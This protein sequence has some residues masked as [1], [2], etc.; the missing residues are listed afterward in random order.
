MKSA[1]K[2]LFGVLAGACLAGSSSAALT[3]RSYIQ[4]GLAACYDGVDNAGAGVHDPNAT[5]WVD[6]TGHGNDGTVGSGITWAANGWV[7]TGGVDTPIV[8]GPGVA[9]VTGSET[10]T[11]EFTGTRATTGRGVLF[12][13]YAVNYGVNMEYTGDGS[14]TTSNALRLHFLH[15]LENNSTLNQYTTA[16]TVAFRNGDSA[17]LALTTAPTERGLWRNAVLGTFSDTTQSEMPIVN[18]TNTCNSCIDGDFRGGS[19]VTFIGTCNAFR[20]Y[21][22]VL[23]A[24]ELAINAAVD[25]VRFRGADPATF[26]LPAGWSFDAQT[27][28]VKAVAVSALGGTITPAGGVAVVSFATNVVQGAGTPTLTFTAVAD[29]GYEFMAWGGDTDAIVSA[30]GCEVT[31]RVDEPLSLYA[32]FRPDTPPTASTADYNYVTD[33]L[34]VWYDGADN[35]G[36]G[37]HDG[38]TSTWT[39]LSGNNRD[40]TLNAAL[41]WVANGWTNNS[42]CYPMALGSAANTA[43]ANALNSN[44]FTVEFMARPTRTTSRENYFGSYNT[45]GLSIEHNSSRNAIGQ[46]RLYYNGKPDYDADVTQVAGEAAVVALVSGPSSQKLYK[47]G[48]LMFTGTQT[49]AADKLLATATYYIGNDASRPNNAFRGTFHSFRVYNRLLTDE[50]VARNAAADRSRLLEGGATTWTNETG[51]AWLDVGSWDYGV[52]NVFTPAA[53]TQAGASKTVTVTEHVPA[54]TNVT[55]ANGPGTTQVRVVDGGRLSIENALVSVGKGGELKVEA[56]GRIDYSGSGASFAAGD[57][58]ISVADGGRLSIDGGTMELNDFKG[59]LIVSGSGTDTG[60]VS[61]AS[62]TLRFHVDSGLQGLQ[63]ITGGRLEMTGGLLEVA[64]TNAFADNFLRL[65]DGNGVVELSGDAQILYREVSAA[66]GNGTVHLRGH[67]SIRG[68]LTWDGVKNSTSAQARFRIAPTA[69]K[70]AVVTV[71][72]D[73][74][75]ALD[76]SQQMFYVNNNA[77]NACA[78]LNWNSSQTLNAPNT[79]A[80]GYVNGYAEVNLTRGQIVAGSYGFRVAQPGGNPTADGCVTGVVNM[81][82]GSI[83]NVSCR[84]SAS[85]VHGLIVGAGTV[86]NLEAPGFFRG[87]LNL[88]GG[89]V[90]NSSCY[91]G[92]GLG[93]SEGDVL[94]TGGELRHEVSTHQMVVGAWGGEGRYV[95]SNGVATAASDV[96]VGGVTTNLLYHKPYA[97]YTV[98]PVTNHC[99]KGLLRVAGGAFLTD[100]TLWVSQDGEGTLEIGPNGSLTA[101]NVTLTNTPAALTGGADLAAKVKFACGPQ[102]VGTLTTA[103]ALTIGPGA[104][105]EVDSTT[106]EAR[107]LFPL[108][109][110]GTCEGDFASITVTGRGSVRKTTTG[111]VLDRSAGTIVIFR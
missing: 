38:T 37:V 105:L 14:G 43:V 106:L 65:T 86:A 15:G 17:T 44:T 61:I 74:T 102:G 90:T 64:R 16:A 66:L 84:L 89:A 73:A 81:T 109:S 9:A 56:G 60:T 87:T 35:A 19:S 50:E 42:S 1:N 31:V 110:F 78:I 7:C 6:L 26:T 72:D 32:T 70:T 25:A 99:A 24:D 11:M 101:A 45:G 36:V 92:V 46:I 12:G 3:S 68:K 20:L 4:K 63:F 23:T 93:L 34:V 22:R 82:G 94:Q 39:D 21:D 59:R 85:A 83:R 2:M 80:V 104:T 88:S 10:F 52:P 95:L 27:N 76:G 47:N 69:G 29:A 28:L 40:A 62:G 54:I 58:T 71:D 100:K 5:T 103:G 111:Y 91:T 49:V 77:A 13:Q 18:R 8:I 107:G 96:F 53:L 51:G 33:G 98:C 108:I 67:S 57:T 75:L 41:G 97:L 79:F 48:Q 55:I 30:N